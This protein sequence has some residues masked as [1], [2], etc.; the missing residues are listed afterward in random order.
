M[1]L[2]E[3]VGFVAAVALLLLSVMI[4]H[5]D[6]LRASMRV[7]MMTVERQPSRYIVHEQLKVRLVPCMTTR[8]RRHISRHTPAGNP[9]AV[10]DATEELTCSRVDPP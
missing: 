10:V 8:P 5:V 6:R 9:D 1:R 4:V 7:I 3:T 2:G